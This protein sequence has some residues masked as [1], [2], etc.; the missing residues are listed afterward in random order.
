MNKRLAVI[1]VGW[2]YPLHFFQTMVKQIMPTGWDVEYFVVSHR[3]P[4]HAIGEK[5]V[6]IES[7]DPAHKLDFMLYK[8]I[9][10]LDDIE[11]C[12]WDYKE[13]PNTMGGWDC[14]NQWSE[15]HDYNDYDMFLF[16]DDDNFIINDQLLVDVLEDNFETIVQA[17][18]DTREPEFVNYNNDWLVMSNAVCNGSLRL[19]GTLD[20]FKK[21]L[22]ERMGGKFDMRQIT[23]TREGK[24][25]TPPNHMDIDNW[26]DNVMAYHKFMMDNGLLSRVR[27]MSPLYRIS[28]YCIEGERGFISKNATPLGHYF[29]EGIELLIEEGIL[30]V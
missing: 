28:N 7:D 22:I 29:N 18:L 12:G 4:S 20:F 1:T 27:Y 14:F 5:K 3:D 17:N 25:D 13:Y 2:H 24:F 21:E 9:A 8:K 11:Q 15:D 23:L 6:S 30:N 16:T 26:N 19:R 10:T